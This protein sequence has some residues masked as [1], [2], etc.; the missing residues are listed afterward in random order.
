MACVP[1]TSVYFCS[2][3]A[4]IKASCAPGERATGGGYGEA[5]GA[6]TVQE[7]RP[8]PPSG[9]PNGWVVKASA[10]TPSVTPTTPPRQLPVY[11]VCAA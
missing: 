4:T 10:S 11:A 9:T 7:D 6:V 2:G 5:T 3:N 8:D 1:E